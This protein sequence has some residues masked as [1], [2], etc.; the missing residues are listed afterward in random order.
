MIATLNG[1]GEISPESLLS[2]QRLSIERAGIKAYCDR[3]GEI[4]TK[5]FPELK[6]TA[7]AHFAGE[8][9]IE[10]TI[11]PALPAEGTQ[12]QLSE[13]MSALGMPRRAP[14]AESTHDVRHD[15]YVLTPADMQ[16]LRKTDIGKHS[17]FKVVV[18]KVAL[19]ERLDAT[20]ELENLALFAR[21]EK[22]REIGLPDDEALIPHSVVDGAKAR[23]MTMDFRAAREERYRSPSR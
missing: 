10:L 5:K 4:L 2:N 12:M 13:V 11:T 17:Q 16:G 22:A 1:S 21:R 20:K 8:H 6:F 18:N 19:T 15:T 7:L 3:L 14:Y 23:L 9:D